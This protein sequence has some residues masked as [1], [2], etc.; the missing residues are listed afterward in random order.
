M[1]SELIKKVMVEFKLKQIDLAELLEVSLSRVKAIT[2]G[3]VK[4][5]TREEIEL[6]TGKLRIRAQWLIS[7]TGSMLEQA[8]GLEQARADGTMGKWQQSNEPGTVKEQ[9]RR[10]GVQASESEALPMQPDETQLL[11]AY[12]GVDAKGKAAILLM[13]KGIAALDPQPKAKKG[14]Q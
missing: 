2:S 10:A 4:N 3:R 7:G 8:A 13:V 5:L 12:R 1:I 14:D 9:R 11:A 6:L